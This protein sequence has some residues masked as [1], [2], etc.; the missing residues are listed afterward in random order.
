VCSGATTS[1]VEGA[2]GAELY[3]EAHDR[4]FREDVYLLIEGLTRLGVTTLITAERAESRLE[5]HA[6]E[7]F[8]FDT[9]ISLTRTEVRRRVSACPVTGKTVLGV[10][11]LTSA[12]LSGRRALLVT[13]DEHPRQLIR[14]AM[15]LGFH[16]S[17]ARG[18]WLQSLGPPS[19]GPF[20][21]RGRCSGSAPRP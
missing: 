17:G 3:A 4:P 7:R 10:Q 6:H 20:C 11:F 9:I 14:N 13:L 1:S 2:P 21:R 19:A 5:T 16:A 15:S 18:C 12:V 8:V